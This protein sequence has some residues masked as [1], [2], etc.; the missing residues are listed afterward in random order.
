MEGEKKQSEYTEQENQPTDEKQNED[1]ENE[2]DYDSDEEDLTADSSDQE[3]EEIDDDQEKVNIAELKEKIEKLSEEKEEIFERMLRIQAEYE[4]Y[5]K[6]TEKERI[7][8]RK[9]KA[10]DLAKELLP[11]LD[12]FERALQTEQTEETKGIMEGITMVYNQLL[13]AMKSQGIEAIEAEGKPF[14]PNFHHAVMQT[15]D[16]NE[17]SNIVIEELQKG[18]ILNDRVIRPSMVKVNK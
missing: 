18:Y 1:A 10:E 3:Q 9:Y 16:E 11:V 8:E 12:N 13:D 6:R 2:K 17:A 7:K 5:K 14:D 15:E 4:N